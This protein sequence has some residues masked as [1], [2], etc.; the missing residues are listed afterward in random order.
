MALEAYP[1]HII[2]E[3]RGNLK[4]RQIYSFF[5]FYQE[6]DLDFGSFA[7]NTSPHIS[8][9]DKHMSVSGLLLY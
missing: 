5:F 7:R 2:G 4:E 6:P 1:G 9:L 8:V 3:K